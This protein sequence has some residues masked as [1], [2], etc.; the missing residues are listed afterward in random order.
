VQ[1]GLRALQLAGPHPVVSIVVGGDDRLAQIR[2]DIVDATPADACV[3][4]RERIAH[5]VLGTGR[6]TFEERR[7]ERRGVVPGEQLGE[8][9]VA[10]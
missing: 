3:H 8:R 4:A 6:V 10:R 2:R 5:R 1:S 9:E 7:P